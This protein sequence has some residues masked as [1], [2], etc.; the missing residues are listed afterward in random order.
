MD[1]H[2]HLC[3]GTDCNITTEGGGGGGY[4]EQGHFFLFICG[5]YEGGILQATG[6]NLVSITQGCDSIEQISA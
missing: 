6:G 1:D 2:Y 5:D 4:H 3:N